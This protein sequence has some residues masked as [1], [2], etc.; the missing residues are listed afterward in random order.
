M[1]VL[2]SPIGNSDP[3]R[4]LRDGAMLHIVRHYKP[5]KVVLFF[6][7]SIFEG[8]E[9]K[10]GH[11]AFPWEKIIKEVS[12]NTSIEI[13]VKD[14]VSPH[15]Y[16]GYKDVFHQLIES[17]HTSDP[18]ATVI[19]NVTSGTPQMGATLCLEYVTFPNKK[20]AIQV[21]TPNKASNAG[22][23]Y[24][25][26]ENIEESLQLVNALECDQPSRC[27]LIQI[28]SFKE[29]M[30]KS[31]IIGFLNDYNYQGAL[32]VFK[33]LKMNKPVE[34]LSLRISEINEQRI[35]AKIDKSNKQYNT[36]K[37]L[38]LF[39]VLKMRWHQ[40]NYSDVLIRIKSLAEFLCY[41][42]LVENQVI[43][44]N[45][46]KYIYFKDK[47][48]AVKVDTDSNS[49]VQKSIHAYQQIIMLHSHND[50]SVTNEIQHILTI[51]DDRNKVAHSLE[52][53]TVSFEKLKNAFDAVEFLITFVYKDIKPRDFKF[54]DE[55]NQELYKY[56]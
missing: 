32:E 53:L 36:K 54:F 46:D 2:F 13:V 19:L 31:L 41:E 14:I 50:T 26:A 9:Q 30:W 37:A 1:Y 24:D 11:K 34:M 18:L 20:M 21:S 45:A 5:L 48:I 22:K 6:T 44:R 39:L 3:W 47:A 29:A 42:Y 49:R 25:K 8:S 51:N 16:D 35:F 55:F 27:T 7:R 56:L 4:D 40:K 52:P 33:Q 15:D 28:L 17:M 43:V 38:C 10:K 23:D 12:P